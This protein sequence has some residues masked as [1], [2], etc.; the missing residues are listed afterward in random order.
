MK[1]LIIGGTRFLG[2]HLVESALARGHEVTLFNRGKS[3][4]DL[5]KQVQTIRGDREKDLDQIAGAYDA[6]IDTCG[7]FPRIVRMSAEA[8]K[9]KARSYVFISSISVYAGFSKIGIN[10]SDPVG[11][12][13]DETIEEITG[14]SY[15]PLKALCENAVQDV[16]GEQALIVRPGLIVGPHDPTDRFTY[17]P[18]RVARGGDV[19]TP[20]KP[21]VPIQII[22]VRD[23]SDFV[24]ELLQQNEFG[25][26]NATGPAHELTLGAMLNACKQVSGS[27]SGAN[28]KWASVEFLNQNQVAPWSDMPVWVPNVPEDA[29][30]SR[31]D[32]SKAM[33]SGLKFMPLEKTIHDTL[34][35]EKS[36]PSDHEWR[37]GLKPEREKEL[38]R[39]LDVQ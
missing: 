23:L 5:F 37:A 21:D 36:R 20:E 13:E 19:L 39:L 38:L 17:W 12:I 24:I 26:F 7:Y 31:V 6:V 35:W 3:N 34:E 10:E 9:G 11:K 18:V 32:I 1:I 14:E 8:L 22:D 2:R 25:V 29:G 4:P 33:R 30:F 28:F 27:G 15:G 16:F